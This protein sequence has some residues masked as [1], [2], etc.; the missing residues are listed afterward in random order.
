[1][2]TIPSTTANTSS[3][4]LTCQ[5]KGRSVQ[6]SLTTALGIVAMVGPVHAVD[7]SKLLPLNTFMA[8]S[9]QAMV[10][11]RPLVPSIRRS[12]PLLFCG[13]AHRG[14]ERGFGGKP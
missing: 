6:R 9:H 2:S 13:I 3:P 8:D 1:M 10:A 4:V 7:A 11:A 14:Q 12:V 5:R